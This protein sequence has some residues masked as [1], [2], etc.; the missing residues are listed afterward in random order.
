MKVKDIYGWVFESVYDAAG[1]VLFAVGISVFAHEASFSPGGISGLALMAN[2]LWNIPVGV[3]TLALNIPLVFLCFCLLGSR[4]LL[5]SLN[6][7]LFFSFFTDAAAMWLPSYRGN[8]L[9]ASLFAGVF[10]GAGLALAYMHGSSTGGSDFVVLSLRKLK[11]HFSV[12]QI[13]LAL[14]AV[15]ILMGWPVF[16]NADAVLYGVLSAFSASMVMDKILYGANSGKLLIAVTDNA[17]AAALNIS[18]QT[19]RGSTILP[20]TGAF[21]G[22]QR[23]LLIC[24]CSNSQIVKVR[25]AVYEM[26]PHAFVIVTEVREVFGEGFLQHL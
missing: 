3:A 26:D 11:P 1:A 10:M 15:I 8:V 21:S 5:K 17:K 12:G 20:A 22:A 14:D 2:R 18:R 19:E 25:V 9:L 16:G 23:S 4:F 7:M 6:T 13:T 24:A